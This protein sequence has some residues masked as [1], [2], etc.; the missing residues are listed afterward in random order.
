MMI[1]SSIY[2]FNESCASQGLQLNYSTSN[3]LLHYSATLLEPIYN[4]MKDKF[5]KSCSIAHGDESFIRLIHKGESKQATM[6]VKSSA[7]GCGPPYVIFQFS[8]DRTAQNALKLH[9]K[10]CKYLLKDGYEGYNILASERETE[11]CA[12]WA[13]VRRK[14]F[15]VDRGG[16]L[17][18][19]F[20][21][22]IGEMYK[23]EKEA[24]EEVANSGIEDENYLWVIRDKQR[25]TYTKDLVNKFFNLCK[26]HV[27]NSLV[28]KDSLSNAVK[29]ALKLEDELRKFVNNPMIPIDNN[30][31]ER[32]IRRFVIG[33]KNWLFVGSEMSGQKLA[34]HLTFLLS[35]LYCKINY[36]KWLQYVLEKIPVTPKEELW[37]LLPDCWEKEKT[38]VSKRYEHNIFNPAHKATSEELNNFFIDKVATVS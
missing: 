25:T 11:L 15:H 12:C 5:S 7:L 10:S 38:I 34:I 24:L 33:R 32:E 8:Q 6:W 23:I 22:L 28:T 36:R 21:S 31:I 29:Y 2:R 27:K 30:P 20:L 16:S 4:L 9:S 3:Y 37:K 17:S 35:C 18:M 19:P 14:F 1:G 26:E 13:H